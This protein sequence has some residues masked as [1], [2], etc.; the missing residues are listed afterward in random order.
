MKK[1]ITFLMAF[2]L[3]LLS[4]TGWGQTVV[5]YDF[6]DPEAVTGL[7]EASPGIALD[8]NIGFGSFKNSSGT[9]PAIYSYQLRLYQNATKGGSIRIY[10]NNGVTITQ[11]VVHASGTTGPAAFS[12]DGA[13][14][15][16]LGIVDG[17][18]TISS[19]SAT[20]E[21]EFWCTG[22]SSGTRIYVDDFEVTYTIPNTP[23][24]VVSETELTGFTYDEGEGPSNEQSFTVEGS[25]LTSEISITAPTNYEISTG[26]GGSFV[27]TSP[28]TL[29]ESGGSV[30]TTT[31]YVRLKAGLA[32][33]TYND[34]DITATSTEATD[35]TITCSGSV[36]DPNVNV[37]DFANSNAT[38]SYNTGSFVGNNG[39]TWNYVASRDGNNDA[40]GS[41]INLPAL[42]L[43]RSSDNS[44]VYSNTIAGGIG[45]FSVKLYKGFTGG[46][47]RQVEL[48]INDISQGTSTAFDDYDEHVFEVNNI[49]VAGDIVIRINNVTSNQVIVDDISWTPFEGNI[50]PNIT[51]ITQNPA[52]DITSSTTVEV[53]AEVTDSDGTIAS[54][55][56]KWGTTSEDYSGGTISMTNGGSGDIYTTSTNIP[57]Q[58]D[59]T[60]VYYI[61][62]ATDNETATATSAE[63]SYLVTDPADEP[64]N[65]PTGFMATA[66][67]FSTITVVWADSDAEAYLI[68]GSD[69]DFAS[70]PAPLDGTPEADGALVH[71]VAAGVE[72]H[73][74]TG[75]NAETTYYFKIFPY[76]G[77]E[78]TIN[79][80]VDG[81]LQDDATTE[82]APA[83]PIAWINEI[84][85]DNDGGD[86]DELIEI[87]I[88]NPG[89]Y[90]LS[91]FLVNLYNG[92]GGTSYDTE[93]AD[94]MTE[95]NTIDTYTFFT[96]STFANG[97]QNGAPDGMALS[98]D[99]TLIQF[100]SYEGTFTATDGPANGIESTDIGVS[101]TGTTPA[102]YSLQLSGTGTAYNDFTWQE[103]ATATPGALNNNQFLPYET[104]W[105]GGAST[106]DWNTSANWSNGTPTSS[107]NTT[108]GNAEIV[109]ISSSTDADCYNLTLNGSLTIKSEATGT[110]SLLVNGIVDGTG[111][112]TIERYV[113]GGENAGGGT[114]I[115]KYHLISIP[116]ASDIQAGDVFTG[117]YLWHFVPNQADEASWLGITSLTESLDNQK[118]F[119]SYVADESDKFIFT[120]TMNNGD[121]TVA[122][123]NIDAG[124][125]KL[126]PNPYP[127]AIDWETVDLT[128]TGLN[129]T[130]WLFNSNT[131]NYESYN[132]GAG[133]GQQYIPVG[134]AVFVEAASADPSLTFTNAHRTHNQGNGFYKSGDELAKDLLKIAVSANNS[135]DATFIRFREQANNAYNGFDDATKLKGFSGAP[136]LFT[137]ATDGKALSINTLATSQETVIVPV[138]FELDASGEAVLSFEYL[139]TFEPEVEIYLE[140]LLTDQM[141]NIRETGHYTF[142]HEVENDPLRFNLHFMGVTAVQDLRAS[143]NHFKVWT[144]EN[145]LYILPTDKLTEGSLQI[146]L[147][148]VSG[149]LI[150]SVDKQ[151]QKPVILS[152]PD[153]D[154]IMLVRIQNEKLVQ[155]QKIF[156]R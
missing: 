33:G 46:G 1:I 88:K 16:A 68:K 92:N 62:E 30:A 2:G 143:E 50:L 43:R 19:V 35:K 129:P 86:V 42:M 69:V 11:V 150:Q 137:H 95:G 144:N 110:G 58:T 83:T 89:N 27:H 149:R 4:S 147:F 135:S 128:G 81:A 97:I 71:N 20:S 104:I 59:G 49:N 124:N 18:Y 56:L 116:L 10:A 66:N 85:Y 145:Q 47:N 100:L 74:F 52:S 34:E 76:N 115:Y 155:T 45:N 57:A 118:G 106:T 21:I 54:V 8:S 130:I 133:L 84:H 152:L 78:T 6:S 111:S 7:N 64:T 103:P 98:Y 101:E 91:K 31:I 113:T 65:H 96:W 141:I 107:A 82:E 134:Q 156:I 37:E 39:I 17:S 67:S 93:T 123:E 139:E 77:L 15:T 36:T 148:D 40:N 22:S 60:T 25:N 75:L 80:K 131:G 108:I 117:T 23:T 13:G 32:I 132:D 90:D 70:I 138:S 48:F 29:N 142:S 41:G 102:G 136:Q 99:G 94:D 51:N 72:N 53:S 38:A 125:V 26:T 24:I 3:V 73:Q 112:T 12:V 55:N 14:N 154:G 114:S 105:T 44:A 109:V 79:Y 121:F 9:D 126:I 153:Y 28:I 146:E 63:Q 127:S 151:V 140:D 87:V 122:A 5:S 119:L 61:I 120:G